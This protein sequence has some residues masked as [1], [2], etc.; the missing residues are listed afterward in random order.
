MKR[1]LNAKAVSQVLLSFLCS[2]LFLIP[3]S[4]TL[5][6]KNRDSTKIY[7]VNPWINTG[8][9][10]LGS[11]TNAIGIK[12]LLDKSD[13]QLE[14]VLALSEDDVPFFDQYALSRD[15]SKKDKFHDY[16]NYGMISTFFSP[17]LLVFDKKA[18]PHLID[19]LT[20]YGKTQAISANIYSYSPLGPTV[21]R[22]FRPISYYDN[23]SIE[24]RISGRR[25]NSWYSGHVSTTA[26]GSFFLAKVLD[27]YHPEWGQNKWWLYGAAAIPPILVG[28]FRVNHLVHFPSDVLG[29]ILV[30]AATGILIPHFDKKRQGKM[31]LSL[32]YDNHFKG[33]AFSQQF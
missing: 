5:A 21:I 3:T 32:L 25:T 19:I 14:E 1:I 9:T 6:Q 20:M 30:G 17:V 15:V 29:G 2:V 33:I 23:V 28:Y 8:I 7:K 12:R 11:Y 31:R 4:N 27:D 13:T 10:V 18:R 22:R 24:D 26:T 16:S